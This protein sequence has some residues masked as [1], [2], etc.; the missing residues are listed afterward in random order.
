M[1]FNDCRISTVVS[2]CAAIEVKVSPACTTWVAGVGDTGGSVGNGVGTITAV[3]V[4]W[5]VGALVGV[6]IITLCVA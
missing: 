5:I 4:A 1:S 6:A 3:A 2:Y